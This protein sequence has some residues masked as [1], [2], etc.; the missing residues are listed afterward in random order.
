MIKTKTQVFL[1]LAL[2]IGLTINIYSG[3]LLEENSKQIT[4][5]EDV[6]AFEF[7]GDVNNIRNSKGGEWEATSE[8]IQVAIDSLNGE[9]GMV[10]VPGGKTYTIEPIVVKQ[11]CI[12]NLGFGTY[13]PNGDSDYM[14][15]LEKGAGLWNGYINIENTGFDGTCVLIDGEDYKNMMT[16]RVRIYNLDLNSNSNV[17]TAFWFLCDGTGLQA[18]TMVELSHIRTRRFEYSIRMSS[19]TPYDG[20]SG[21][22]INAN[23]ISHIWMNE[24]KYGI[25]IE[26]H[27][28]EG[29]QWDRSETSGNFFSD[30]YYQTPGGTYATYG[31]VITING[32]DYNVFDHIF[33]WDFLHAPTGSMAFTV[34][35]NSISNTI[36]YRGAIENANIDNQGASTTFYRYGDQEA[37]P[38]I[39]K[40]AN[41]D[42]YES[43]NFYALVRAISYVMVIFSLIGLFITRRM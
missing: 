30:I 25:Y 18:I 43:Y 14:F 36:F 23:D 24:D 15:S 40:D 32:G 42:I 21:C 28:E 20:S 12:L 8:N 7:M 37:P 9:R 11:D 17:G 10:W 38:F 27:H 6:V 16:N 34:D 26:D 41:F 1:I 4:E 2:L 35:E 19:I 3:F 13:I 22:F 33:V 5:L 39:M 31:S 29:V